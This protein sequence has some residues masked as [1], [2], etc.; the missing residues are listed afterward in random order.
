MA[1][2]TEMCDRISAMEDQ[3][4]QLLT[5]MQFMTAQIQSLQTDLTLAPALPETVVLKQSSK[6]QMGN[7]DMP[8]LEDD[9]L[10]VTAEKPK[11]D[12]V[13]KM[14]QDEVEVMDTLGEPSG[15]FDYLVKYSAPPSFYFDSR[16]I[17][18]SGWD[19]MDDPT[20]P[21]TENSDD[22][23]EGITS[24]FDDLFIGTNDEGPSEDMDVSLQE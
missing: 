11:P 8:D 6:T 21:K 10:L 16:N 5:S 15:N 2:Q 19:D 18:P 7:G 12:N 24:L 17:V 3:L 1:D 20:S 14:G 13:P 4:R 22:A 9:P 23:L